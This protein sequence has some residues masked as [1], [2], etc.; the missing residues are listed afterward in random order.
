MSQFTAPD[1]SS[2]IPPSGSAYLHIEGVEEHKWKWVKAAQRSRPRKS[3][4]EWVIKTLNEAA[5]K[6]DEPGTGGASD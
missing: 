6:P 1:N 2:P 4:A 3:L 5:E